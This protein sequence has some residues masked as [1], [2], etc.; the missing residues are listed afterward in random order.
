MNRL[1]KNVQCMCSGAKSFRNA[2][3]D[4]VTI[5]WIAFG[6]TML[7]R[8]DLHEEDGLGSSFTQRCT[9]PKLKLFGENGS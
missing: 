2:T 5:R 8:V 3:L 7:G 9:E 6:N 4:Q 1:Q